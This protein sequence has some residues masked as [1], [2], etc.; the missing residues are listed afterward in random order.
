VDTASHAGGEDN[1]NGRI[2]ATDTAKQA[3]Q[4]IHGILAGGLQDQINQ[5]QAHATTLSDPNQWDGPLATTF[6]DQIWPQHHTAIT[7][8]QTKIQELNGQVQKIHAD[9]FRAGGGA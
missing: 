1:V 3:V 9:I 4:Q 2:L 5:L 8:V 7:T 6:R